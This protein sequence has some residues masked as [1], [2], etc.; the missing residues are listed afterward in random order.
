MSTNIR[1]F[2]TH[3]EV[4]PYTKGECP[5][6]ENM[7]SRNEMIYKSHG[8][9][10]FR[11][12]AFGYYINDGVLY[13]PRGFNTS[14]LESHFNEEGFVV[15]GDDPFEK[16]SSGEPQVEPN[17]EIQKEAIDFLTSRGNFLY[18]IRYPQLGLSLK[19]GEGKT[20]AAIFAML[21]LKMKTIAILH[22]SI[23]RDQWLSTLQNMTS[24]EDDQIYVIKGSSCIDEI[25]E[26]KVHADVYLVLHMTILKYANNHGWDKIRKLFKM[27]KIGLKIIDE[28]HLH[29]KDTCMIDFFSNTKKTFYL[30]ATPGRS[31]TKESTVF[32][33]AFAS[34]VWYGNNI[35]KALAEKERRKHTK[36]IIMYFDS[37]SSLGY[38]PNLDTPKGF[39]IYKY[40]DYEMHYADDALIRAI[41]TIIDNTASMEGKTLITTPKIESSEEVADILRTKYDDVWTINSSHSEDENNKAKS[42]TYISSTIKS[43]GEGVDIKE[44][45]III[46]AEPIGSKIVAEQFFG[47]LREYAPDKFTYMYHLVDLA[48]PKSTIW[49]NKVMPVFRKKAEEIVI[50]NLNE[51]LFNK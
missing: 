11:K 38:I 47:R 12:E 3:I 20:Y 37:K 22:R 44:L 36:L 13:L 23:I 29:F 14:I 34:V 33:R 26:G 42:G 25:L 49:L 15:N 46:N 17:T 2:N 4:Y 48:I 43:L 7:L 18:S 30:T 9:P 27:M 50:M 10:V 35:D 1:I 8:H 16:I 28:A 31:D 40:I 51:V 41:T 45:R 39:S 21:V 32:N 6:I 24:L 5:V 19:T